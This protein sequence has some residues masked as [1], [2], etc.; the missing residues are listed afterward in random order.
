MKEGSPVNEELTFNTKDSVPV[1][2]DVA[3]SYGLDPKLV[4]SFYTKFQA[5]HLEGFTHGFLRDT[6]RNVVVA[7]GSEYTFDDVNGA[8]KE[9]FLDRIAKALNNRVSAYGVGIQQFGLIGALRPPQGLLEA[10]AAIQFFFPYIFRDAMRTARMDGIVMVAPQTKTATP[11]TS[12]AKLIYWGMREDDPDRARHRMPATVM[13]WHQAVSACR[14]SLLTE[15]ASLAKIASP[16]SPNTC[17]IKRC[18]D[19]PKPCL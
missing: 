2:L 10:V 11:E 18:R 1:N 5:D 4:P 9:E 13:R 19:G 12:L 7:I 6:A 3:V 8:K 17:A 15:N 14:G 16:T